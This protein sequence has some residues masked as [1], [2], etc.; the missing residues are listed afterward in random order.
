MQQSVEFKQTI[1]NAVRALIIEDENILLLRKAYEDG[2]ERFALPGGAQ[3]PGETLD[4]TLYRECMEEIG[5]GVTIVELAFLADWFK[6]RDTLPPTKRQQ[7]EFLFKCELPA[8][9]EPKNG[10]RPD[11]HQVDVVWMPL[12]QLTSVELLPQSLV[13]YFHQAENVTPIYLGT[14]E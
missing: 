10:N 7:V 2:A 8:G 1:R 5:A 11:K 14:L 12:M 3:E 13:P 6:P 4:Q 9:Y